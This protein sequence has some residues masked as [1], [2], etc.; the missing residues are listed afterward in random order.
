MQIGALDI[1]MCPRQVHILLEILSCFTNPGELFFYFILLSLMF[2][3]DLAFSY[4]QC[5]IFVIPF[6]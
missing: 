1:L 2:H 3:T 4:Q 6:I 5:K